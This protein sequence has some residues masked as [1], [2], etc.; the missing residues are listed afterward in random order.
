MPLNQKVKSL[1]ETAGQKVK[2]KYAQTYWNQPISGEDCVVI[3]I[4]IIIIIII[5]FL[6]SQL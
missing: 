4:I 2:Y 5:E 1:T 6:T 3:I